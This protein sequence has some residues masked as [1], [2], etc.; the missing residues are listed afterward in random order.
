MDKLLPKFMIFI[1]PPHLNFFLGSFCCAFC[2]S[3]SNSPLAMAQ[4]GRCCHEF[5]LAL[6]SEMRRGAAR[7]GFPKPPLGAESR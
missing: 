6:F 2:I 7:T 1:T 4:P 3:S 5:H